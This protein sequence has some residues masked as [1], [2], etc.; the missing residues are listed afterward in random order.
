MDHERGVVYFP[1]M[2]LKS[3]GRGLRAVPLHGEQLR[4][5]L[6]FWDRLNVHDTEHA[7]LRP[8]RDEEF[9][10]EAGILR[11]RNYEFKPSPKFEKVRLDASERLAQARMG[12]YYSFMELEREQPGAWSVVGTL[13]WASNSL[14]PGRGRLVQLFNVLPVPAQNT[15]LQDILEFKS[16]RR[17]ELMKL[18]F[19][20]EDLYTTIDSTEDY[21]LAFRTTLEKIDQSA[22]DLL[23]VSREFRI[24]IKLSRFEAKI[25]AKSVAA[26]TLAGAAALAQF[27][28]PAVGALLTGL[29]ATAAA[30]VSATFGLRERRATGSPFEY[31]VSAHRELLI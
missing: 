27:H 25:D 5:Y 19:H 28:F 17:D 1:N 8:T 18:R 4:F 29:S 16:R 2:R 10:E 12:L 7:Q 20:L 24:P 11:R 21:N 23:R 6:L 3:D 15:P 31:L 26:G 9:L 13:P 30:S 14:D 22:A